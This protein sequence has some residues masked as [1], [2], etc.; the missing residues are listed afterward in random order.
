MAVLDPFPLYDGILTFSANPSLHMTFNQPLPPHTIEQNKLSKISC[1]L[2]VFSHYK[3]YM[4]ILPN[5]L[6]PI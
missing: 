6:P 2:S 5:P 1:K 3:R 4:T